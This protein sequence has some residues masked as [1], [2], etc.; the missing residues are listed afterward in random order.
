VVFFVLDIGSVPCSFLRYELCRLL[1]RRMHMAAR[2]LVACATT[3]GSTREI[4]ERLA[5]ILREYAMV[6]DVRSVDDATDVMSYNAVVL[7]SPVMNGSWLPGALRFV[8]VHHSALL[9]RRVWLFSVGTFGDSHVLLG[10]LMKKEPKGIGELQRALRPCDYRVF[11]GVI[12]R[13]RWSRFGGVIL[14][15]F[16]GHFGDN[17]DWPAIEAWGRRIAEDCLALGATAETERRAG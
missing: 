6:A 17:R 11:A 9:A 10:S 15:L 2:V 4:A 13:S 14:Y 5:T 3:F 12:D 16:G 1:F 8:E 7:G